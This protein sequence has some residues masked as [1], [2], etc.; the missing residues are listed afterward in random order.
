MKIHLL[1]LALF[2]TLLCALSPHARAQTPRPFRGIHDQEFWRPVVTHLVFDPNGT[3]LVAAYYRPASNRPGTNWDTWV[4]QWD[5][6]SGTRTI[7]RTATGPVAFSPD[8][9]LFAM[10][11]YERSKEPGKRMEP[12]MRLA[13]WRFAET[14]PFRVLAELSSNT[15]DQ[16]PVPDTTISAVAFHPRGTH[17]AYVSGKGR[18]FLQATGEQVEPRLADDLKRPTWLS[19]RIARQTPPRLAF[20][21][22]GA[23]L[24]LL[25]AGSDLLDKQTLVRWRADVDKNLLDR[26]ETK[27]TEPVQA[28]H[29]AD[30]KALKRILAVSPDGKLEA[31]VDDRAILYVGPPNADQPSHTLRLD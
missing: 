27:T 21:E 22:Q 5:L 4:A 28:S 13:L 25:D 6:E 19:G 7:V 1:A 10:P 12:Q 26:I 9:K 14:E 18:V 24:T 11:L 15:T 2:W 8:G 31:W 23:H 16:D 29:R 30:V 20:D 17:L 3:R